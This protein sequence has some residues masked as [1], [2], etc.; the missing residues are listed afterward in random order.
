MARFTRTLGAGGED[1]VTIW[2]EDG[3]LVERT[4]FGTARREL[5]DHRAALIAYYTRIA[6]L[7]DLLYIRQTP[8]VDDL[9]VQPEPDLVRAIDTG[10]RD[11]LTVY[12]DWL[13]ERGD[14]RGE[15]ATLTD[16]RA[17]A[18]LEKTRGVELFGP[19]AFLD[20][21]WKEQFTYVWK[22]G[23]V[24][25][26]WFHLREGDLRPN[27]PD[28]E[29]M[30]HA[31]HAPM[32]RFARWL[33]VDDWYVTPIWECL[34][35]CTCLTTIRGI[36]HDAVTNCFA[37]MLDALPAL[38]ELELLRTSITTGGHRNVTRMRVTVD[39]DPLLIRGE[40]PAL[41]TLEIVAKQ[42]VDADQLADVRRAIPNA[43]ITILPASD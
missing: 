39:D 33:R 13:L 5:H 41:R 1:E 40:W 28:R 10:D 30:Q 35:R 34:D 17:I 19:L 7:L 38:E 27:P 43:E 2:L 16:P 37:E 24:D 32:A 4:T 18:T 26:I 9:V 36:R 6:E 22:A 11:A 29:V 21:R 8:F 3:A 23:W 20:Q 31:L 12:T 15:R 42:R 14:A 25:E